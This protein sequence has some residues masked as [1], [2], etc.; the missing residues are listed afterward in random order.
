MKKNRII[1]LQLCIATSIMMVAGCSRNSFLGPASNAIKYEVSV[2]DIATKGELVNNNEAGDY[3]DIALTEA[4][5]PFRAAAYN[6]TTPI[7]TTPDLDPANVETVSYSDGWKMSNTYYW[8]Q[9]TMLTF[10]AYGNLP[11]GS[12]VAITPAGQTLTHTLVSAVADQKDILLG[13]YLGNGSNIG[14]AKI[15]FQHPL[16]AVVFKDAGLLEGYTVKS[17]TLSRIGKSGS[18]TMSADGLIG[19]WNVSDYG[20]SASQSKEGGLVKTGEVIGQPFI[21]IPQD[22]GSLPIVVT[23]EMTDGAIL[24][25]KISSGVFEAG[26]TNTFSISVRLRDDDITGTGSSGNQ[27][28][29]YIGHA[30]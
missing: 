12:S 22:T 9:N 24:E 15:R 30:L 8:P 27:L 26:K 3:S 20:G 19:D 1:L 18:T 5:S 23:V 11:T 21:I 4:L 13:Y 29:L 16:T 7:F 10:F 2:M 14:T 28:D 25:S 17:I 6:G